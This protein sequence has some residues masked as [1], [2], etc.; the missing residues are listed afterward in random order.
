MAFSNALKNAIISVRFF[1]VRHFNL[2]RNV[3]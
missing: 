3:R 1:D 2:N